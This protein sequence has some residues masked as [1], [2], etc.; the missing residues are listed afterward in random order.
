MPPTFYDFYRGKRVLVTGH[1]SFSGG[2][3]VA[4][5]KLLGAQVCGYG[6]P[7]LS[8]PNFFDATAL[9]QGVSSRFGDIRDRDALANVFADFQ[10][11]IVIHLLAP[12]TLRSSDPVEIFSTA[13]TG[14]VHVLEEARLTGS[15]HASVIASTESASADRTSNQ[16]LRGSYT[17]AE[18]AAQT[19]LDSYFRNSAPAIAFVRTPALIGGGDFIGAALVRELVRS[20]TSGTPIALEL[21]EDISCTHVLDAARSYLWLAER[22]CQ[23]KLEFAGSWRLPS[24]AKVRGDEFLAKFCSAS[25]AKIPEIEW[26]ARSAEPAKDANTGREIPFKPALSP[27]ESIR[28]SAEWY[29]D[30]YENPATARDVTNAQ[31]VCYS[32]LQS[33]SAIAAT[34]A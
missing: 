34:D 31:I 29:R 32:K 1:T 19:Y 2:W 5:L 16:F 15:A 23:S 10:P 26:R 11:E 3:L 25:G 24:Q 14:T 22:L 27:D 9:E 6:L 13:V 4:W 20:I 7:P 17:A 8:R 18:S 21:E 33:P 28:W 30:F 12:D